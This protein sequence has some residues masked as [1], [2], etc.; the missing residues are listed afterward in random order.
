[1]YRNQTYFSQWI[2]FS[3]S[4]TETQRGL[5][6]D[7]QTSGGLLMAVAADTAAVLLDALHQVGED[8]RIIGRVQPG[9]GRLFI[10]S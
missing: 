8:A 6:F 5:L 9:N 1:M 2:V 10:V 7:P 4:I 3:D